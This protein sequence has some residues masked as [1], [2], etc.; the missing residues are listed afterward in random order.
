[1]L[2]LL[3]AAIPMAVGAVSNWLGGERANAAN[4]R[5]ADKNRAFQERM[6]NT[7][8]QRAAAD[9]TAAGGNPAFAMSH[10]GAS[11]PTGATAAPMQNS[12]AGAVNAAASFAEAMSRVRNTDAQTN[13]LNLESAARLA[14]VEAR[15]N[16]M[17]NTDARAQKLFRW[18]EIA[19]KGR[20]EQE[21]AGGIAANYRLPYVEEREQALLAEIRQSIAT[22]AANAREAASRTEMNRLELPG[23]RNRAASENTWWAQKIRPYEND[24]RTAAQ[25][26]SDITSRVRINNTRNFTVNPRR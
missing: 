2:P 1:M 18:D 11:S 3:A 6:S 25:I 20:A 4:A 17:S 24:A 10:G 21:R 19:A 7:S 12:A 13:Q 14:E 23:M 22:S 15:A 16:A 26:F 8:Y 9:I 5:E